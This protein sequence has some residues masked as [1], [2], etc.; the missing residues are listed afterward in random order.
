M[1]VTN[2]SKQR[3][4]FGSAPGL[5]DR[6][7]RHI[8]V[9]GLTPGSHLSAQEM[10]DLF[11]A[12]RT[13]VNDALRLLANRGLLQH[14]P[15]RGFFVGEESK[16]LMPQPAL[17]TIDSAYATLARDRLSGSLGD[18]VTEGELLARYNLTRAQ[19]QMLLNRIAKEGWIER[20]TGYGWA[21]TEMLTTA[22][23][24]S[25]SFRFRCILEPASLV[26][27]GYKLDIK[28]IVALRRNEH[29]MMSGALSSMPLDALFE[30]RAQFHEVLVAGS[31]NRFLIDAIRRVNRIRR[32]LSYQAMTARERYVQQSEEHLAILDLL[33]AKRNR[34]AADLL[35][36][37]LET[38]QAHYERNLLVSA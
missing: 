26:E 35:R 12:S 33:E 16:R 8:Q 32:L 13:P 23:G 28:E 18:E 27:P 20:R 36:R 30:Q 25:E 5:A 2:V 21:F 29:A 11:G 38:V 34:D 9:R 22:D 6:I 15:N 37:H 24:L 14:A 31:H 7:L 19:M 10:A 4:R 1:I 17:D 3:I